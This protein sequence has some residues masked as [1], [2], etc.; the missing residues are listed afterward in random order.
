MSRFV[1]PFSSND[2]KSLQ[3]KS[4]GIFKVFTQASIDC[5]KVNEEINKVVAHKQEQIQSLQ[6]EVSTLT[7]ISTKNTNLANKIEAFINA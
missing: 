1:S 4:D 3:K 6:S 2:L 5:K 7:S